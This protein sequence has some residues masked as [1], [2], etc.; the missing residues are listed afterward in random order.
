MAD[1]RTAI[2]EGTRIARIVQ[3]LKDA[4]MLRWCP[5]EFTLVGSCAQ[6]PWKQ[7]ALLPEE[8]DGANCAAGP[9]EGLEHQPDVSQLNE[10][11][12]LTE[13]WVADY[14]RR[15]NIAKKERDSP[16]LRTN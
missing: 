6:P 10:L 1:A 13:R 16:L 9:F 5:Q 7:N 4:G 11:D 3:H 12:R 14:M 2:D 15:A 8:A